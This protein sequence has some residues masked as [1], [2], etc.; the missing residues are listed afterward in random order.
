M[1][2]AGRGRGRGLLQSVMTEGNKQLQ[3][4][5]SGSCCG[6]PF[7]PS[8][9]LSGAAVVVCTLEPRRMTVRKHQMAA[10]SRRSKQWTTTTGDDGVV[11]NCCQSCCLA[12]VHDRVWFIFF[13]WA[14]C[15]DKTSIHK[16]QLVLV[17]CSCCSSCRCSSLEQ[18][19]RKLQHFNIILQPKEAIEETFAACTLSDL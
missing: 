4:G 12:A 18:L 14:A 1:A 6:A 17:R 3:L 9:T 16:C 5:H 7:P 19:Q 2:C 10:G 11:C 8:L 13:F 15:V